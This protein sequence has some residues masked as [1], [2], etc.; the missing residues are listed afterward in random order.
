MLTSKPPFQSSTTDEIYRRARER[1]YEWP[2]ADTA[3]KYVSPEAKELVAR[4]LEDATLRPGPDEIVKDDFFV[5]GYMPT[6]TD[7]TTKPVSYTHL[8]LPTKA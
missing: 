8:T 6:A 5:C 3:Q 2:V 4:M 7:I 1:D